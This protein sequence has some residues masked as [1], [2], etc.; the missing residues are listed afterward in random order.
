M[1]DE[2]EY[3]HYLEGKDIPRGKFW[4]QLLADSLFFVLRPKWKKTKLVNGKSFTLIA[5]TNSLNRRKA[6][7]RSLLKSKYATSSSKRS[8]KSKK[9]GKIKVYYLTFILPDYN[10]VELISNKGVKYV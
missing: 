3:F 6:L 10:F 8:F 4:I 9:D 5:W 7:R 2:W 1:L